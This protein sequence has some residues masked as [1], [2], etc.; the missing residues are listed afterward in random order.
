VGGRSGVVGDE[1]PICGDHDEVE[2][3][4]IERG[5][6]LPPAEVDQVWMEN[7]PQVKLRSKV[8]G[9]IPSSL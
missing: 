6:S 2:L 5:S 3:G 8:S 1:L 4:L 7:K 9:V